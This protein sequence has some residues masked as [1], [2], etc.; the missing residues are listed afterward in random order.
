MQHFFLAIK[1]GITY[2]ECTHP[3]LPPFVRSYQK[4]LRTFFYLK[5]GFSKYINEKRLAIPAGLEPATYALEVR[6]SIQLSYGTK[7]Q[8]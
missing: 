5:H 2:K 1:N 3:L 4:V 8:V 7:N 6:C